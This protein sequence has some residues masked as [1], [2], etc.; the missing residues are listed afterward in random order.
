MRYVFRGASEP[1]LLVVLALGQV[2]DASGPHL[3]RQFDSLRVES[4]QC[5]TQPIYEPGLSRVEAS[6]PSGHFLE[7]LENELCVQVSEELHFF[8]LVVFCLSW[9]EVMHSVSLPDEVQ[10]GMRVLVVHLLS[11]I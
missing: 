7:T 3:W 9:R 1:T 2:T 11:L 6:H 4:L 5:M 10:Q 8:R